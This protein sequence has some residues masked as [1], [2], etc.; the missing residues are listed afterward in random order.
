MASDDQLGDLIVRGVRPYGECRVDLLLQDGKIQEIASTLAAR[1]GAREYNAEGMVALP[2]FVDLHAHLRDPGDGVSEN[3]SSGCRAAVAGGYSAVFA[4]ANTSPVTDTPAIAE[5]VVEQSRA[6]GR[7]DVYPV[8]AITTGLKGES[9]TDMEAM[10]SSNAK[11][12]LFS[13]DGKCVEDPLVMR[14]AFLR[15]ARIGATLAQHAQCSRLAANGQVNNGQVANWLNVAPWP[16]SAEE[17][18]IARDLTLLAETA[19]LGARLHVCHVSTS[20]SVQL[21]RSAKERKLPVTA[22]VTPHHLSLVDL[23]CLS[24]DTR[25]KVNP[26]LRSV[27]DVLA[28]RE[29]L[30]DGIIDVVATDHAPHPSSMKSQPWC[31]AP[32]GMVGLETALAVVVESM[33]NT[34]YLAWP[35]VARVMSQNPAGIGRIETAHG[36]SL[37]RGAAATFCLVDPH[38][39]WTVIAEDL[40]GMSRNTPF[41][42]MNLT[43]RV[44]AT[45]VRGEVVFDRRSA[46]RS[47]MSSAR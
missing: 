27:R 3:I 38:A 36:L 39:D 46:S 41:Q 20:G 34:G 8:G 7:C 47:P 33:V 2:G 28:L 26:P 13:D 10:S 6:H 14:Q 43:A 40:V 31:E 9:V 5:Y 37:V 29:G 23:A 15:S 44:M 45:F 12:R 11:V 21:I 30:A 24:G 25:F 17:S 16:N 22:E 18:I 19:R 1:A 32:P 35:D 4:M 42:G